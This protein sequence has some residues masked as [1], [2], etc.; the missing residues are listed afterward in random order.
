MSSKIEVLRIE[1]GKIGVK[2][3]KRLF[4]YRLKSNTLTKKEFQKYF[5]NDNLPCR[6]G[7]ISV[8]L[9]SEDNIYKTATITPQY[10][11]NLKKGILKELK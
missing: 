11:K 6:K 9:R 1:F 3:I 4:A 5:G 10:F 8:D 2:E 7:L